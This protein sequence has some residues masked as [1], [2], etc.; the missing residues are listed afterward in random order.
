MSLFHYASAPRQ[1]DQ[2][3]T[4]LLAAP[5]LPHLF[6]IQFFKLG[7]PLHPTWFHTKQNWNLLS[8]W[9]AL[10]P[11]WKQY[12]QL[13][14]PVFCIS[15][16]VN[17]LWCSQHDHDAHRPRLIPAWIGQHSLP[18]IW[19]VTCRLWQL[20]KLCMLVS[21]STHHPTYTFLSVFKKASFGFA[22]FVDKQFIPKFVL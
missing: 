18:G 11:C 15:T 2:N 22:L 3:T 8:E 12:G 13:S 19:F 7:E 21:T 10:N 5:H 4:H 20:I 9:D 17:S 14:R 16:L 1:H 6:V